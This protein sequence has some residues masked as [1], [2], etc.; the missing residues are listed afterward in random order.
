[1]VPRRLPHSRNESRENRAFLLPD[2]R[3]LEVLRLTMA[4]AV[5]EPAATPAGA[6]FSGDGI[7]RLTARP[8]SFECDADG[9][10]AVPDGDLEDTRRMLA[11]DDADAPVA[12]EVGEP[13][14]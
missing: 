1:M 2:R 8:R 3:R 10:H 11:G 5:P 12:L 14:L 4:P 13:D 9:L 7:T 6:V